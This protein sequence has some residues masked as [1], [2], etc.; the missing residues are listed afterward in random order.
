MAKSKVKSDAAGRI[1]MDDLRASINKS[2]GQEVAFDL[3]ETN[4][5][6]VTQWIPT[7]S[8]WLDSI[9]SRGNLAGIPVG[10]I[11]EIAGLESSGKSFIAAQVAANAQKMGIDVVYFDSENALSPEFLEK[12][13]VDLDRFMYLQASSIEFV[14]ETIEKLLKEDTQWLF[15]LDSLALTPSLK[16]IEGDYNPQSTIA[17]KPRILAKGLSKLVQPLANAQAAFL[18]LNQL[19]TNITMNVS[20]AMTTPWITPGGKAAI[21]SYS[22]RIWLT[23]R[24]A[25]ASFVLDDKGYRI[26]TEVKAKIEKSRFG[27]EGRICNFKIL[28]GADIGVQD[29]ESWLDAI[30]GSEYIKSGGA[31]YTMTYADGTTEKFQSSGWLDKLKD[32]KFRQ[33]VLDILDEEVILKFDKR[34]TEAASYY[35][36]EETTEE[37]N[38]ES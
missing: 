12:A 21:Y 27:T 2:A 23:K 35:D 30:K 7:G 17:V 16:D 29:E 37:E 38:T 13:G 4:P 14:L 15:I 5:T 11:S 9:I 28:W 18:I 6:E 20:E 22:L 31:W 10:K 19:K 33:R 36:E 3:R 32:S 34:L 1:S 26:G 25:K 24:K 8:R